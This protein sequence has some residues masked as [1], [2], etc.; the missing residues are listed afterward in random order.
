MSKK[1]LLLFPILLLT[2]LTFTA[3]NA[4]VRVI[5]GSGNV[6]TEIR[7]VSNF[8][9]IELNG[10][11]QVIVTQGGSESLTIETDDNV[12]E[13][14]KAEVEG[15]TLKLGLVTGTQTGVN[16]QSTSR[17]VFH[18]GVDDLEGLT[19]SGSGHMESEM[20]ES[21]RLEATVNG[22]G[23]IQIDELSASQVNAEING[24]GEIGLAGDLTA[25]EI[26]VG[27]SGKYVGG[28]LCSGSVKVSVSG[29]GNATVCVNESLDADV[30]GSGSVNYYG[31]PSSVNSSN[32]G[33]GKINNLGEK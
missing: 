5:Q 29:S 23:E 28:N 20:I 16:I 12:M 8:A 33:S 1:R 3:C 24:S 14:I 4:R 11:G 17:L 18:V 2:I 7:Q 25:Q 21:D 26:T 10:S 15:G 13:H 27:G 32:S 19:V 22:S 6:I 30:S 31:Q 9:S